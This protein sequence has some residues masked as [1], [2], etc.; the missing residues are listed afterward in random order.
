MLHCDVLLTEAELTQ[1]F[2]NAVEN[3]HLPEKFFYWM[4]LSVRAWLDLCAKNSPYRNFSRSL[5]V[6]TAHAADLASRLPRGPLEVVSLGAGQGDKDLLIL[7]AL[8]TSGDRPRYRPLDAS[9]S[10]LE[11]ALERAAG[12]GFE[13]CGIKADVDSA[14]TLN[15]LASTAGPRRLYMVL[16]NSLGVV[17]PVHFL[18]M[19]RALV[20]EEDWLLVD[21][22]LFDP[23]LS[24]AGYDNPLNRRFAFA[25]LA[26]VGLEEGRDGELIFSTAPGASAPGVSLVSK[27]FKA[28]RRVVIAL[29]GAR[30]ELQPGEI[31]HMNA[32]C[33]YAPGALTAMLTRTGFDAVT[34]YQSS[35]GQ[36]QMFLAH[37]ATS[38]RNGN[39]AL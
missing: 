33:K 3:R 25:P 39:G 21:G 35:D 13:A 27:H 24:L 8:H 1:Q 36:F 28:A 7:E 9:Q 15:A 2:L 10:L 5:Q 23:E 20:R 38:N 34:T 14:S 22:E 4:P 17:D 12:G 6:I 30:L 19:L 32:S 11:L 26:G 31:V 29:A 18:T 16:G 37:P